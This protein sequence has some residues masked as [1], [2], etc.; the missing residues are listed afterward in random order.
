MC[1]KGR[2][3]VHVHI[4]AALNLS[5]MLGKVIYNHIPSISTMR[6]AISEI[7]KKVYKCAHAGGPHPLLLKKNIYWVPKHRQRFNTMHLA[8]LHMR[9]EEAMKAHKRLPHANTSH[10]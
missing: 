3:R 2:P 4:Y 1:L 6:T 8:V 10:R 5:K 7:C 9:K